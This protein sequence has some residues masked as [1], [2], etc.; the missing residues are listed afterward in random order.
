MVS[1]GIVNRYKNIY[2]NFPT[3]EKKD[4]SRIAVYFETVLPLIILLCIGMF[5]SVFLLFFELINY[6]IENHWKA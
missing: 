4:S 3:H 5:V 6:R 1:S 2:W